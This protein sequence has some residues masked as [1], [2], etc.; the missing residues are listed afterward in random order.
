MNFH[1]ILVPGSKISLSIVRK[2]IRFMIIFEKILKR[3]IFGY[4]GMYDLC[5]VENQTKKF[6]KACAH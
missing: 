2:S 5:N 4:T 3:A 6:E 1:I